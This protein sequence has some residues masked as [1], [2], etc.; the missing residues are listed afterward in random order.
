MAIIKNSLTHAQ[1]PVRIVFVGAHEPKI[2]KEMIHIYDLI[3]K[4]AASER[5]VNVLTQ[6]ENSEELIDY[7]ER[8]VQVL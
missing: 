6:I 2:N 7:L 8:I 1:K 3:N 5:L 4:I